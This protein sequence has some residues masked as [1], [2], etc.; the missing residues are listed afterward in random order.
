MKIYTATGNTFPF[1]KKFVGW[2][3]HWDQRRKAWIEDNGSDPDE[4]CIKAPSNFPGVVV[5]TVEVGGFS[6]DD[7][8]LA[9]G[10]VADLLGEAGE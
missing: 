4:L 7:K 5:C 9:R 1:R 10:N 6:I 3:W 2:G 8:M